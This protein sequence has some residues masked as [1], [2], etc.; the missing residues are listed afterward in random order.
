MHIPVMSTGKVDS[1]LDFTVM[2][3]FKFEE[4]SDD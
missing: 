2:L 4:G 3:W 1:N